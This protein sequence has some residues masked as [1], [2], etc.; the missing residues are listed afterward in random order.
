MISQIPLT[1]EPNQKFSVKIPGNTKNLTLNF[2]LSYNTMAKYWVL[3]IYDANNNALILGIPLLPDINLLGQYQ[4]L[5]LGSC[6]LLN[7]GD[8]SVISPDDTNLA[9]NFSFYWDYEV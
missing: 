5:G 4:Y 1:A 2:T 8:Q 3:G 9:T 7:T 6:A